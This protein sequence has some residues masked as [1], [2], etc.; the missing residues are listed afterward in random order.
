M[1]SLKIADFTNLIDG[2]VDVGFVGEC[3][4]DVFS[5]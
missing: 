2:F 1:I 5:I 4:I 3:W